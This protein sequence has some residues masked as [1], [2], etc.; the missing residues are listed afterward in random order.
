MKTTTARGVLVTLL[1][2]VLVSP[3]LA[4]AAPA[5]AAGQATAPSQGPLLAWGWNAIGQLGTGDKATYD[6]PVL[7]NAPYG[8]RAT[9]VRTGNFSVAV[10]ASGQVYAWGAGQLGEL[11]NGAIDNHLR[12]V[13]T[14]LPKG[15]RV[16]AAREGM[17]FVVAL[18]TAGKVLA[19]GLGTSGQL[20]NG[21]RADH[22]APVYARLPRG[23]RITAVSACGGCALGLTSD[24]RVLAWGYNFAGQLGN[25]RKTGS[26]VPV[27][28]KLPRHTKV[29]SIAAG[30]N[31]LFAVTSTG[32][33]LAWGRN[34]H[35][36][37]GTGHTGGLSRV[38][39]RVH[40]P[41]GVRVAAVSSGLFHTVALTTTGKVLAW[42][43][44]SRGQLGIGNL[45]A[46]SVPVFVH[47]PRIAH[48]TSVAAGSLHCLALTRGGTVLGWGDDT[49]GQLGDGGP[50]TKVSPVTIAVPARRVLAIGAGPEAL[51]SMVVVDQVIV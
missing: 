14:R 13:K 46:S 27:W 11:G 3:V 31:Q 44:N 25:G 42:G 16:R 43:D 30:E 36:Q 34:D 23:V 8:L 35:G 49:Y 10:N 5:A 17:E 15:V 26:T 12:P 18:T 22:D 7:V 2:A 1:A 33:L 47:L 32:G 40:L 28:V 39:V 38:P 48:I 4:V 19:W 29:T 9:S 21:H 41:R 45:H 24:G 37:L 20:G 51:D 6:G 50:G